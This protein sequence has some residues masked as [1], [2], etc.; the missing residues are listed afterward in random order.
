KRRCPFDGMTSALEFRQAILAQG[1]HLRVP[2]QISSYLHDEASVPHSSRWAGGEPNHR[3]GQP[4]RLALDPDNIGSGRDL[5]TGQRPTTAAD[6]QPEAGDQRLQPGQRDWL[7][8]PA[9]SGDA[10][11]DDAKGNLLWSP[12]QPLPVDPEETE[13]VGR[14]R[15]SA[16]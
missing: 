10:T 16:F 15:A 11:V 1:A 6:V 4:P 2:L 7:S 9:C 12:A 14:H 5:R 8:Q 3:E 13:R